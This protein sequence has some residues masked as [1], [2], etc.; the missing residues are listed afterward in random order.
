MVNQP[1][2]KRKYCRNCYHPM[3]VGS[4]FCRH[5]SQKYTTGRV[6]FKELVTEFIETIFNLDSRFFKTAKA[7][8]SPGKLTNEYFLGKHKRYIHPLRLFLVCA[9][10]CF[11]ALG[12]LVSNELNEG[13]SVQNR[14]NQR[15]ADYAVYRDSLEVVSQEVLKDFPEGDAKTAVDRILRKLPDTREDSIY[16]GFLYINDDWTFTTK[17]F[18]VSK[19]EVAIMS[20]HEIVEKQNFDGFFNRLFATQVVKVNQ[21]GGSF[22]KSIMGKMIWMIFLMMP[23]LALLLKLLYWRR[24]QFYVEHLIFSFHYHAFAFIIFGLVFLAEYFMPGLAENWGDEDG[25]IAIAVVLVMFYLY[26][27][28]RRVYK[29]KRLKTIIKFSI[30]NFS[31]LFIFIVFLAFTFL[32]GL[33]LF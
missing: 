6:T 27:S 1:S 15:Q 23:A 25:H 10:A 13:F 28:M 21:E 14:K 32:I 33:F 3:A 8:L 31:Y 12:L 11:A 9:V 2:E 7:L 20:P 24:G 19:K 16:Y 29:Q 26:K 18:Q 17:Q 5:C 4:R 22:L 30:L